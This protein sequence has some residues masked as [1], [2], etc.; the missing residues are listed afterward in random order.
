[1]HNITTSRTLASSMHSGY[2]RSVD[3]HNITVC[4]RA[5][6][7]TLVIYIQYMCRCMYLLYPETWEGEVILAARW[8]LVTTSLHINQGAHH[9]RAMGRW[10]MCS[11][12]NDQRKIS[13]R[14]WRGSVK[15]VLIRRRHL[16][17]QRGAPLGPAGHSRSN[18]PGSSFRSSSGALWSSCSSRHICRIRWVIVAGM[19]VRFFLVTADCS[20]PGRS[21]R[22]HATILLPIQL[23]GHC[24]KARFHPLGLLPVG[25]SA[26]A[27]HS[28][29]R[30]QLL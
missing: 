19:M 26:C 4:V 3:I 14:T 1:M 30:L 12:E 27:L 23:V 25:N 16:S 20:W 22:D 13:M 6:N 9:V 28:P 5:L 8:L 29:L 7:N 17:G 15:I 21:T 2:A 18:I 10:R 11:S 24:V